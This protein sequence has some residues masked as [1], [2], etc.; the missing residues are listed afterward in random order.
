MYAATYQLASAL[1]L[2]GTTI[3]QVWSVSLFKLL[4]ENVAANKRTIRRLFVVNILFL[5]TATTAIYLLKDAL[6]GVLLHPEFR[7]A[8]PLFPWLL[9]GFLFQSLYFLFVNFDFFDGSTTR[10]GAVTFGAAVLN[11]LLNILWLPHFGINGSA[12]A[13]AASMA[14]YFLVVAGRVLLFSASFRSVWR[15]PRKQ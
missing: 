8:L 15:G 10:I 4:S 12:W 14:T 9:V 2:I 13:A 7:A 6:F 3:N 11:I 1:L 5:L